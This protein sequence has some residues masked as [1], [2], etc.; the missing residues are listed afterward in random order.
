MKALRAYLK[1][2]DCRQIASAKHG[3]KVTDEEVVKE[4][5]AVVDGLK[6]EKLKRKKLKMQIRPH[7]LFRVRRET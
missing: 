3:S 6:Q 4:I 1:A 5:E 7:L 2:L